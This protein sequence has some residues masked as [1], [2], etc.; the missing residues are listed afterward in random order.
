MIPGDRLYELIVQQGALVMGVGNP[1][2]GDDAVGSLVAARLSPRFAG[3]AVDA[4][5]V[6]ESFLGPLLATDGRPVMFVDAVE[7]GGAP[8]AWC[9]VPTSDLASRHASTHRSSLDLLGEL[10]HREGVCTWVLGVQ[11]VQL[12]VGA[13]LSPA[14]ARTADELTALLT[15]ALAAGRDDA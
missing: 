4:G 12:D 1:L 10:L 14:V 9:L 6:P 11:P 15:A 8:G 2:C 3:R 5:P 13:P 7:H